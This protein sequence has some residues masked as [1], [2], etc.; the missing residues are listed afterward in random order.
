MFSKERF[1]KRQHFNVLL[2][3]QKGE[4]IMFSK[5]RFLKR[6][7]FN[8]LFLALALLVLVNSAASAHIFVL[9]PETMT[10]KKGEKLSFTAGLAEPLITLDMSRPML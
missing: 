2:E 4:I 8:V 10:V 9:K 1:L 3:I 7:H 6:Q 5:E